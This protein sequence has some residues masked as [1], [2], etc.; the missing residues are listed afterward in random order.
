MQPDHALLIYDHVLINAAFIISVLFAPVVSAF[1]P[2]WQ[3]Q[4]GQNIVALEL[5]IAGTLLSSFLF[6]D[7]G[8]NTVV[9]QWVTAGFLTLVPLV[10]VWRTALI[11]YAQRYQ[12]ARAEQPPPEPVPEKCTGQ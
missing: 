7:F 10:I 6:V 8:I 4:W 1:W 3:E 2:W 9:L 5:C 11:W 12:E